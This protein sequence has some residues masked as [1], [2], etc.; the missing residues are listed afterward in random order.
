MQVNSGVYLKYARGWCAKFLKIPALVPLAYDNVRESSM[1]P[2]E[3]KFAYWFRFEEHGDLALKT[4]QPYMS[5]EVG[6]SSCRFEE[7]EE[8]H[9]AQQREPLASEDFFKLSKCIIIPQTHNQKHEQ[10]LLLIDI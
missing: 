6:L 8:L 4:I 7:L 5:Q 2:N 3:E 10:A 1:I 9:Q